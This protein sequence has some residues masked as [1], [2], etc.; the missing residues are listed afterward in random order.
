[1]KLS[2]PFSAPLLATVLAMGCGT[3][4][5]AAFGAQPSPLLL[6]LSDGSRLHGS[7]DSIDS[8]AGTLRLR[9]A[10]ASGPV[11]LSMAHVAR[12]VADEKAAMAGPVKARANIQF[13]GGGWIACDVLAISDSA[14]QCQ[15]EDGSKF[16]VERAQ[17]DWM[18]FPNTGAA[19]FY[20]GPS[21]LEGWSNPDAWSF[22]DGALQPT[23]GMPAMRAFPALPDLVEYQVEVDQGP[24]VNTFS[25]VLRG[26]TLGLPP[27]KDPVNNRPDPSK[28]MPNQKRDL[29]ITRRG[30]KLR[31]AVT[32][33]NGSKTD[34]I[35][36]TEILSH[37][38]ADQA[39]K[40]ATTFTLRILQDYAAGKLFIFVNHR[41]AAEWVV[42]PGQRGKNGG[43]FAIE[44]FVDEAAEQR[45]S[46]IQVLPWDGVVPEDGEPKE[47][48]AALDRILLTD[49]QR[50]EGRVT[51]FSPGQIRFKTADAEMDLPFAKV[52]TLR[53]AEAAP[54]SSAPPPVARVVLARRGEFEADSLSWQDGSLLVQ[55]RFGARIS[56]PAALLAD[57]EL[58]APALPPPESGD[59]IVFRGGD[60]IPGLL[61]AAAST[62][63]IAWR[64]APNVPAV[65]F[66]PAKVTG[67]LLG[68]RPGRPE[69]PAPVAALF[70]NGDWIG[71]GLVQLDPAQ[72]TLQTLHA[73][74]L[75]LSRAPLRAL[76]FGHNG[77]PPVGDAAAEPEA[78]QPQLEQGDPDHPRNY[79]A[80]LSGRRAARGATGADADGTDSAATPAKKPVS[81]W[82]CVGGT[83]SLK[84]PPIGSREQFGARD[85][86][87]ERVFPD[88]PARV[89]IRFDAMAS[90]GPLTFQALIFTDGNKCG[91]NLGLNGQEMMIEDEG[92]VQRRVVAIPD[93]ENENFRPLKLGPG[94]HRI[95]IFADR[96]TDTVTILA[97]GIRI[98]RLQPKTPKDIRPLGKNVSLF[99]GSQGCTFSNLWVGAWSGQ[100]PDEPPPA[101]PAPDRVLLANGDESQGTVRTAT[102]TELRMD[103][104]LGPLTLVPDRLSLVEFAGPAPEPAAGTRLRLAGGGVLSVRSY[105]IAEGQVTCQSV[106]AGDLKF[107]LAALQEVDFA[108]TPAAQ[109]AFKAPVLAPPGRQH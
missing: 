36:L 105:S 56:V 38:A 58:L 64:T 32:T 19:V 72:L 82:H 30:A 2:T 23:G 44:P 73:G 51:R 10:A 70:R 84:P 7:I 50:K 93:D 107:P 108:Q 5:P 11:T 49:G 63:K 13:V 40:P 52:S 33:A 91:Y 81:D 47:P 17:V 42:T 14:L 60:R 94:A 3:A 26:E 45:F 61:E 54:A 87:L 21:G 100:L 46:K 62:G 57:V 104:D 4:L 8:A 48:N 31:L 55:T 6:E 27:S 1:M 83:F 95:Q 68:R 80:R 97:D 75:K 24:T 96:A 66:D 102:A 20:D 98:R 71:G 29:K 16:S 41:K 77:H 103:W 12:I 109:P 39:P 99:P 37:A 78:W 22:R 101:A 85:L 65:E 34:N 89:E 53:F 15:L 106:L 86:R 88:M 25:I 35:D 69:K 92:R 76:Y 28:P 18:S 74:M 90:Q 79:R 67:L 9:H 43:T 59:Q